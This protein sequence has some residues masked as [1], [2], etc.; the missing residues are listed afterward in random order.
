MFPFTTEGNKQRYK[1]EVTVHVEVLFGENWL[2]NFNS[3]LLL[4]VFFFLFFLFLSHQVNTKQWEDN[5]MFRIENHKMHK[6]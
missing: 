4:F 6:I 2:K 5:Y 3:T 1:E